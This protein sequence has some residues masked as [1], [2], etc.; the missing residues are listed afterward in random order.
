M[1]AHVE[2]L[3][4]RAGILFESA[5]TYVSH[6]KNWPLIIRAQINWTMDS[7]P[8]RSLEMIWL[9]CDG[10]QSGRGKLLE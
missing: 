9:D 7:H 3:S 2:S 8:V 5:T 10:R 6:S 4:S 1:A